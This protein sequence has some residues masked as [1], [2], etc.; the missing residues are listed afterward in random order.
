MLCKKCNTELKEG[1]N[2]CAN[3]GDK[4]SLDIEEVVHHYFAFGILMGFA[5]SKFGKT[6]HF[7]ELLKD[8]EKISPEIRRIIDNPISLIK[9]ND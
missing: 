1:D 8:I 7:K 5:K 3:C 6:K 4:R 2:Y 9:E